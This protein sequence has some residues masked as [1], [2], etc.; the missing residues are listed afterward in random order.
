M[1]SMEELLRMKETGDIDGLME[2]AVQGLKPWCV[3]NKEEEKIMKKDEL[4]REPGNQ[5]VTKWGHTM[6]RASVLLW[7]VLLVLL[8]F[9]ILVWGDLR[10]MQIAHGEEIAGETWWVLCSPEGEV[11]IRSRPTT[12]S[13][14]EGWMTCGETV[15]VADTK[16]RWAQ[17]VNLQREASIGWVHRGYLVAGAVEVH[18]K[19]LSM[20]VVGRGRVAA[21]R[22]VEGSR[23]KWLNPR[24]RVVV[25]AAGGG[26][27]VT[28]QGFVKSEYLEEYDEE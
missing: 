5:V 27:A 7:R 6:S 22:S 1:T 24:D 19:P 11:N 2:H 9:D 15:E 8:I 10:L 4:C 3:Q 25:Y 12:D 28:D 13:D 23:R 20:V 21:R 18:D 26:W 14:T 17:C 16:A